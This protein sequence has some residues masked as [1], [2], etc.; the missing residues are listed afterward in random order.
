[1]NLRPEFRLLAQ[2]STPCGLK[3]RLLPAA[4]LGA[5]AA[6][7]LPHGQA[8]RLGSSYR[9]DPWVPTQPSGRWDTAGGSVAMP[10]DT[11]ASRKR[12]GNGAADRVPGG[13]RGEEAVAGGPEG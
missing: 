6:S 8:Y 3:P 7:E 4:K 10:P 11:A 2:P 9:G 12:L 5:C 1:M 13:S